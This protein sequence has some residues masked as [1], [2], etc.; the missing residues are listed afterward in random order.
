MGVTGAVTGAVPK[1]RIDHPLDPAHRYLQHVSVASSDM[2]DLYDGNVTTDAHGFATVRVPRWFQAL[3]RTFCYQLTILGHAP[4][5]TETR[6]WD[7]IAHNRFT[8]RT[9]RPQVRVSWEV[10]GIR[11]DRFAN[12]HRIQAVVPKAKADRG[13]YLYPRGYGKPIRATIGS[14]PRSKE[15][16]R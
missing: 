4:W 8:I 15:P 11:H 3:N 1:V 9:S 5:A 6:V 13:K 12:A 7:E 14:E 16:R 10:T 2:L